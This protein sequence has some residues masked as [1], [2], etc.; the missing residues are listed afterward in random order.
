MP[1]SIESNRH[2]VKKEAATKVE[3]E[4]KVEVVA[5]AVVVIMDD[6]V[7]EIMKRNDVLSMEENIYG[8]NA[9]R[10]GEAML[11]KRFMGMT[12]D[13]AEETTVVV[14]NHITRNSMSIY[15]LLLLLLLLLHLQD[16]ELYHL[17]RW[18]R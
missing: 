18:L 10:I 5:V 11:I 4:K 2:D 6:R 1:I 13:E 12:E 17:L 3:A 16:K 14:I 9:Q 7:E 8:E 15:Q